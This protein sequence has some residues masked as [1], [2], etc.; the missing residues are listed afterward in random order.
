MTRALTWWVVAAAVAAAG[1]AVAQPHA[2][3]PDDG[4]RQ[5]LERILDGL[6]RGM[7]ALDELDR[8]RLQAQL[9]R[10]ADDVRR[11]MRELVPDDRPR[12]AAAVRI[13]VM[14]LARRALIDAGRD[15]EAALLGRA[16]AALEAE[17]EGRD[18]WDARVVR[19]RGPSLGRQVDLLKLAARLW[20]ESGYPDR[21]EAVTDL[22]Q[23]LT[24]MRRDA[25]APPP[26]AR[27]RP[28]DVPGRGDGRGPDGGRRLDDLDDLRRRLDDIRRV[29][30]AVQRDLERLRSSR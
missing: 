5:R 17:R 13:E 20:R 16:I 18:D 7:A 6:E 14:R 2:P 29:L 23:Q 4:Q 9:G 10:V 8:P 26:R 24:A 22:A 15:D 11:R 12:A 21:A 30:D 25:A 19:G 27:P 1:A 3:P 28:F